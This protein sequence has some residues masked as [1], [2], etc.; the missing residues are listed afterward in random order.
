MARPPLAPASTVIACGPERHRLTWAAGE[1]TALDHPDPE[2]DRTLAAL[3]GDRYPCIEMLDAWARHRDDPRVLLIASRG[4][5][6]PLRARADDGGPGAPGWF[7]YTPNSGVLYSPSPITSTSYAVGYAGQAH[8]APPVPEPR[9]DL[10]RIEDLLALGGGVGRRLVATVAAEWADR[11]DTGDARVDGHR[12]ALHAAVYGRV[13]CSVR[14]WLDDPGVA[15]DL[16]MIAPD[17]EPAIG[18]EGG[19][20]QV[21]LPLRWLADVWA[22]GT[23]VV[24]DTFVLERAAVDD[25]TVR[26][27]GVGPDLRARSVTVTR[28]D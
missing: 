28:A 26:L 20:F 10:A 2:G 15:V 7:S 21:A 18:R 9:Q 27:T 14:E 13:R 6:D 1:L 22:T 8:T 24:A 16:E 11:I 25:R 17:A 12:A 3:G 4:P 5:S 23:A 19:R